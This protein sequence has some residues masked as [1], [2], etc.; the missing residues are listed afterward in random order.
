[1]NPK[2]KIKPRGRGRPSLLTPK[3]EARLMDAVKKGMPLKQ[4]AMLAGMSY[5]TLNRWRIQGEAENAPTEFRHFW[6]ALRKSQALAMQSLVGRIRTASVTDWKA[7]AWLLERRHPDE[8]CRPQ[9]LEH[10]GPGGGPIAAKMN[11]AIEEA[12]NH[13]SDESL[14][15]LAKELI[16]AHEG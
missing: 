2:T 4:A 7:A 6:Q 3:R 15:A 9:R 12:R 1:M 11:V 8:F 10:S 14:L 5:E 13:I 16:E